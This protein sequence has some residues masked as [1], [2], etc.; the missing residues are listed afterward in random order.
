[1]PK[2]YVTSDCILDDFKIVISAKNPTEAATS[3]VKFAIN[4]YHVV[5]EPSNVCVDER[6]YRFDKMNATNIYEIGNILKNIII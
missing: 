3:A 4:K 2:Y 6:G 5:Y 1:M